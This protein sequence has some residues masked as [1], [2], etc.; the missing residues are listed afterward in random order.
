MAKMFFSPPPLSHISHVSCP[1]LPANMASWANL[2]SIKT[3][4]TALYLG[5]P[6]AAVVLVK[7]NSYLSFPQDL[8]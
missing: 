8:I 6:E 1:Q 2:A 5:F 3:N 4:S 7:K